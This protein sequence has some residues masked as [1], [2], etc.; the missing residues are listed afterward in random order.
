MKATE[1]DCEIER[2]PKPNGAFDPDPQVQID[3]ETIQEYLLARFSEDKNATVPYRALSEI[4]GRDVREFCRHA[5]DKA[6]QNLTKHHRM[7]I[8]CNPGVGLYLADNSGVLE[9]QGE[10]IC[11]VRGQATRIIKESVAFKEEKATRQQ[12]DK[13]L[14]HQNLAGTYL[15]LA[16]AK[17]VK[18]VEAAMTIKPD[19]LTLGKTLEMFCGK[20]PLLDPRTDE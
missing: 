3:I 17:A 14:A 5:M 19:R 20:K 6:R 4:L 18:R 10:R 16:S 8:R 12:Q 9:S 11:R 15:S 7:L 13:F 1:R 2:T